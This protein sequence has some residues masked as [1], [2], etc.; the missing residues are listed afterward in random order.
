M[1]LA[2]FTNY[3][4]TIELR[5]THKPSSLKTIFVLENKS[6]IPLALNFNHLKQNVNVFL[7]TFNPQLINT[8]YFTLENRVNPEQGTISMPCFS[9]SSTSKFMPRES[10]D[11]CPAITML[12]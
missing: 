1:H 3:F 8:D 10:E 9:N 6:L 12:I 4:R 2:L 11:M 5:R 7:L